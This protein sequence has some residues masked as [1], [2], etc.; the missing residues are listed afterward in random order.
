[1]AAVCLMPCCRH[2]GSRSRLPTVQGMQCT[3]ALHVGALVAAAQVGLCWMRSPARHVHK[4]PAT[5]DK[6]VPQAVPAESTFFGPQDLNALKPPRIGQLALNSSRL[7]NSVSGD[8]TV[9]R[10]VSDD[11]RRMALMKPHCTPSPKTWYSQIR[12]SRSPILASA[13]I[14]CM[15]DD[16]R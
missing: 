8:W 11:R 13:R 1:M 10:T 15:Q 3:P 2:W 14:C 7:G 12:C 4:A 6:L 9:C 16:V 5:L